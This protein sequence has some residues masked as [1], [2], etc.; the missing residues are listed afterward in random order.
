MNEQQQI[1]AILA[2][3]EMYHVQ[4]CRSTSDEQE[5]SY[6]QRPHTVIDVYV[7]EREQNDPPTVESTLDAQLKEN[8]DDEESETTPTTPVA[9]HRTSPNWRLVALVALCT[10]IIGAGS[11]M[12][13][14]FLFTPSASVTIVTASRQLTTTSALQLVTNGTADP[15][16]NQIAGRV[17]LAITMS[18]QKTLPTTGTVHQM[19]QAAHGLLTFYNAAPYAQTI[20]AGT[21]LTG[22]DG[23]QVVTDHD[24]MIPAAIM[25]TEGQVTVSAH[26]AITGLQGN[27]RASDIY[28]QCCRLNVFVANGMFHGGQDARTYQTVT[29]QGITS[30]VNNLKAN[31][32]Q[33]VQAAFQIQVQPSE[34]LVIPLACTSKVTTDPRIGEEATHVQ[35]IIDETCIG[36]VYTTQALTALATQR[37][38]LDANTRL[39]TGY[40]TTGVHTRITQIHSTT[41]DSSELTIISVSSWMYP[42]TQEQ[43][44]AMKAMIGGMSKDKAT[45]TLLH[46]AGVQSVSITL[47]NST[48]L[49][50]DEQHISIL[51]LQI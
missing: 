34:T 27:I 51:F 48:T 44:D 42:F 40:T 45:A 21:M 41:H 19:A 29:Q 23:I 46:M 13:L 18:Q 12:C 33:S 31:L 14:V 43:Q 35:V 37:T 8:Q 28:G 17:L 36:T 24:A 15:T 32:E 10:L 47:K 16:K 6:Q 7:I 39:G 26:T 1:D 9:Q 4:Q 38:T 3:V 22:A 20:E 49:P 50:T 2:N 25:P 11:S 30:V 5:T